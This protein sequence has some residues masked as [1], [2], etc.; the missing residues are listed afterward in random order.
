VNALVRFSFLFGKSAMESTTRT[1]NNTKKRVSERVSSVE[2]VE[3]RAQLPKIGLQV[4]CSPAILSPERQTLSRA[5]LTSGSRSVSWYFVSEEIDMKNLVVSLVA[6]AGIASVASAQPVAEAGAGRLSFQVWNGSSWSSTVNAQP[7]STVQWRAVVSYTGTNTNVLGLGAIRY[8]PTF[9]NAVN[10][11][12]SLDM[13]SSYANGGQ[14]GGAIPNSLASA[15]EGESAATPANGYGRVGYGATANNATLASTLTNFRHGGGV[16]AAGAPAGSWL[17][18]AGSSVTNWP[19][20]TI[21][22]T[23][24][25]PTQLNNIGRGVIA[26]QQG[27]TIFNP[28][29]GEFIPNSA[30]VAGTQNLVIFRGA[31]TLSS[32]AGERTLNIS[33]AAG[34]QD[35]VGGTGA[36]RDDRFMTWITTSTGTTTRVGVVVEGAS[37]AIPTPGA[38]ALVGL[39]GLVAARRRR[40]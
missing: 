9:S 31:I 4:G 3:N 18:I 28:G 11:G 35:R 29:T 2:I 13:L 8:Q 30:W 26:N 20:A 14:Q 12:G 16:A 34:S 10:S 36:N 24:P 5:G 15:A 6:L 38:L 1:T 19:D 22:G 21:A 39:G 17:R 33:S 25:T 23:A 40:A 37:I 27:P 7:G 32:A